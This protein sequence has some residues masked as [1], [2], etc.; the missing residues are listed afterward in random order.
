MKKKLL[1]LLG[2]IVVFILFVAVRFVYTSQRSREGRLQIISSPHANV[3]IDNKAVG[4]TPYE[5]SMVTGEYVIK[6]VPNQN[7]ASKSATW[8]GKIHIYHNT[9]TYV[10]REIGTNMVNSSGVILTVQKMDTASKKD[11]GQI[12]IRTEPDGSIVYLDDEEQGISPLI[13]SDVSEGEHEL[14]VFSPGFFRRSQKVLV[15]DGYKVL[16][17]YQLAIDPTHKRVVKVKKS[18]EATDE[19]ALK[20]AEP[21]QTD[22]PK[23]S[24]KSI[25][26]LQTGTGW[27]RVRSAPTV[28]AS[29]SAKVNPGD[30]FDVL[31][32]KAGWYKIEYEDGADGWI[33]SQYTREVKE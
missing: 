24:L 25:E 29:E 31:E 18:P 10:S 22:K 7:E 2:L 8:Q 33:S 1:F 3:I 28:S 11:T 16:A 30:T 13:L 15:E 21:T 12:E 5:A 23:V 27:L 17:D 4:R 32:E 9:R 20:D 6:L 26:I 14:S 19:A